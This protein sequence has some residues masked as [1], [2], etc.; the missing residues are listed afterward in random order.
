M[1]IDI[2]VVIRLLYEQQSTLY[3]FKKRGGYVEKYPCDHIYH[4]ISYKKTLVGPFL[5]G[6]KY[7]IRQ[8]HA[9]RTSYVFVLFDCIVF[10]LLVYE[11]SSIWLN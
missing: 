11:N 6:P 4:T 8:D 7:K 9:K 1:S 2:D 3:I 5:L 10:R